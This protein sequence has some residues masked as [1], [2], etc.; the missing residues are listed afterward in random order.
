MQEALDAADLLGKSPLDRAM[1]LT[2][3]GRRMT[4]I[5]EDKHPC[6]PIDPTSY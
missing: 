2:L 3:F 4:M 1:V 5:V 6:L